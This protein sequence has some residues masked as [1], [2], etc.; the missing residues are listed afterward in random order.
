MTYSVTHSHYLSTMDTHNERQSTYKGMVFH[1]TTLEGALEIIKSGYLGTTYHDG[2]GFYVTH[3]FASALAFGSVV[4]TL[5]GN[6]LTL[7]EDDVNDGMFHKGKAPVSEILHIFTDVRELALIH[8]PTIS[9]LA[10]AASASASR[11]H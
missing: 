6:T 1:A 4:I 9:P 11:Q 7:W 10:Q 5:D 2:I 3:N 8:R